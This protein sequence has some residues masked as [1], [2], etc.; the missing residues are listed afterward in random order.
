[1]NKT[2]MQKL[3]L[4]L[5]PVCAVGLASAGDSVTVFD[6]ATQTT[7]YGAY[8]DLIPES[9]NYQI[10]PPLAGTLAVACVV[11]GISYMV[12][13]KPGL[14]KGIL[15]V[16]ILSAAAAALPI[17]LRGDIIV[18]PNVLFPILMCGQAGLAYVMGKQPKKDQ[19]NLG[20]RLEKHL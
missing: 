12:K 2:I 5:L 7:V 18:V 9:G 11:L 19:P 4:I 10:L 15:W 14:L 17:A 20:R 6:P 13:A 16:G 1:M 8:F 3:F